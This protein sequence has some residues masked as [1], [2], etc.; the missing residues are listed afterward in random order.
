MDINLALIFFI[1]TTL[2]IASLLYLVIVCGRLKNEIDSM[3]SDNPE[4]FMPTPVTQEA[5]VTKKQLA[6][7]KSYQK[8]QDSTTAL[9]TA[10]RCRE[11]TGFSVPVVDMLSTRKNPKW[12]KLAQ[13]KAHPTQSTSRKSK[14]TK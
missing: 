8:T 9:P 14:G 6:R 12:G 7:W 2:G 4:S 5:R 11:S 1:M 13:Q 3:P 10:K